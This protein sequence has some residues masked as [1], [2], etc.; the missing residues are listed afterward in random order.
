MSLPQLVLCN[1][2]TQTV[3]PLILT[4]IVAGPIFK[5]Q[6]KE[7]VDQQVLDQNSQLNKTG[8]IRRSTSFK[9]KPLQG[10]GV[11]GCTYYGRNSFYNPSE[12]PKEKP[13]SPIRKTRIETVNKTTNNWNNPVNNPYGGLSIYNKKDNKVLKK[14]IKCLMNDYIDQNQKLDKLPKITLKNEVKFSASPVSEKRDEYIRYI[15]NNKRKRNAIGKFDLVTKNISMGSARKSKNVQMMNIE[16]VN[17]EIYSKCGA[18]PERSLEYLKADMTKEMNLMCYDFNGAGKRMASDSPQPRN[19]TNCFRGTRKNSTKPAQNPIQNRTT[20]KFFPVK[21]D[22]MNITEFISKEKHEN[23][24][25]N[26]QMTEENKELSFSSIND[27]DD[28]IELKDDQDENV[29]SK[30]RTTLN[31][32]SEKSI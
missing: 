8:S 21:N 16:G 27:S 20:A 9:S 19:T 26:T 24:I 17:F 11:F 14:N 22:K 13:K 15:L 10:T 5:N 7:N 31:F 3:N 1:Q 25:I 30:Q 32:F 23:N 2:T 18:S 28:S 29:K 6:S 4:I 12:I